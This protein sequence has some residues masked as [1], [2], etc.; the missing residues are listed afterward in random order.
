MSVEF[1]VPG[2][3]RWAFDSGLAAPL[4]TVIRNAVIGQ[5]APLTRAGGGWIDVLPI[6]FTIKGASDD[7]GIEN[8]LTELNGRTPAIA[9][10]IGKLTGDDNGS[11]TSSRGRLVFELY[12][13]SGHRRGL[14]EGR[15]ASDAAA[16]ASRAADPG[17]DAALELAWMMLFGADLG[18]GA[19]V[20]APTFLEEDE[21]VASNELGLTIWAQTWRVL[22]TRDAQPLR[23]AVQKLTG[24]SA[25]LR[26]TSTPAATLAFT[27]KP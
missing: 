5:L 18:V 17:L 23:N 7:L 26:T 6:G 9:V 15:I 27:S 20:S 3:G 16:I 13:V 10:A 8:L 25:S 21:I 11:P 4:R 22:V 2:T 12:F 19:L 1:L 14:T 24:I